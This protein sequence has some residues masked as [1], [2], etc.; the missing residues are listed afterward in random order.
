M[1][2]VV[3]IEEYRALG[4][5]ALRDMQRDTRQS[6]RGSPGMAASGGTHAA[7]VLLGNDQI[8][9]LRCG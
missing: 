2:A 8:C 5:A 6:R 9:R 1:V 4:D 7:T 3:R